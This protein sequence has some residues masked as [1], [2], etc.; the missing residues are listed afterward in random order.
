VAT[1]LDFQVVQRGYTPGGK[2]RIVLEHR[3]QKEF[4]SG[5][6]RELIGLHPIEQA[7]IRIGMRPDGRITNATW[8]FRGE[9]QQEPVSLDASWSFEYEQS[10]TVRPSWLDGSIIQEVKIEKVNNKTYEVTNVGSLSYPAGSSVFFA[11]PFGKDTVELEKSLDP[12]ES[13]YAISSGTQFSVVQEPANDPGYADLPNR[14]QV[15]V[16]ADRMRLVSDS[17]TV[18]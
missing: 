9:V 10:G 18:D 8:N 6:L 13:I 15:V 17:S 12:G 4:Y 11:F 3:S 2:P 5:A 1:E 16:K 7:H 14:V